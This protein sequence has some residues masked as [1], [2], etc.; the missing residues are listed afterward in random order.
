M[1]P[2]VVQH[3][4]DTSLIAEFET[5][6]APDTRASDRKDCCKRWSKNVLMEFPSALD[7]MP[8][9]VREWL[10]FELYRK[11]CWRVG[12]GAKIGR[13]RFGE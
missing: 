8:T 7:D 1:D 9:T 10:L 4:L 3:T 5:A 6:F 13:G 11:A 2:A 12:R